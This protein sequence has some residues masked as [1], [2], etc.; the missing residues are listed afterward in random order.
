MR[1]TCEAHGDA[2]RLLQLGNL[3]GFQHR[4]YTDSALCQQLFNAVSLLQPHSLQCGGDASGWS[5]VFSDP[6]MQ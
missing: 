1:F 5:E 3:N 2:D 4:I 6:W